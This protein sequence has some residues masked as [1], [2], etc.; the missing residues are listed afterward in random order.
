[1]TC[2]VVVQAHALPPGGPLAERALAVCASADGLEGEARYQMLEHGLAIAEHALL[3]EEGRARAHFAV[4]CNLGKQV[5][6]TGLGLGN[7]FK[8]G[9]LRREIDQALE[10]APDDPELL[11]AKGAMLLSLPRLLGGD[12]GEAEALLRRALARDPRHRGARAYLA[13]ALAARGAEDEA[14]ALLT[15]N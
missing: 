11:A 9:R 7:L 1:M 6:L 3:S 12:A 4:F 14:A 2:A 15:A 10:I 5:Q 8:I 13:Q